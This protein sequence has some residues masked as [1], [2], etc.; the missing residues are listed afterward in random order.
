MK[1]QEPDSEQRADDRPIYTEEIQKEETQK[2]E[3][4]K[5]DV[6]KSGNVILEDY[7]LELKEDRAYKT[8]VTNAEPLGEIG[9]EAQAQLVNPTAEAQPHLVNPTAEPAAHIRDETLKEVVYIRDT[10]EPMTPQE[11]GRVLMKVY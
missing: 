2:E 8:V 1:V 11:V 5:E 9:A 4:Q 6:R 10:T 3:T 7:K